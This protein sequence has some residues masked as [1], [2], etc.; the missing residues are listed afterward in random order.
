MVARNGGQEAAADRRLKAMAL[1][2]RLTALENRSGA[3]DRVGK[4][5]AIVRGSNLQTDGYVIGQCPCHF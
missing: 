2:K 3:G 5:I 1:K 4:G